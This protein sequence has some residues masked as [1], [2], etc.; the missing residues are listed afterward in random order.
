MSD[1]AKVLIVDAQTGKQIERELNKDELA[2]RKADLL[3]NEKF[4][5][6]QDA[7][8]TARESALAKLKALGLTEAEISAL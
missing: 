2:E 6:E 8:A 4:K 5:A 3:Q 7:K 1:V